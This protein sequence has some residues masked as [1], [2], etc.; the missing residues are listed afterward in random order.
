MSIALIDSR[1]LV[2]LFRDLLVVLCLLMFCETSA[3]EWV[4]IERVYDGDT[5]VLDDGTKVRV[6]GIDTP[7]THHPEIGEE[8]GGKSATRLARYYLEGKRVWLIG[9]ARDVYGRRLARVR[10]KDNR[11]YSDIVRA[12]GYDKNVRSKSSRPSASRSI[13]DAKYRRIW[14]KGYFRK[15]GRWVS[16][17]YRRI[18]VKP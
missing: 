1:R 6:Q 13:E 7:E 9:N 12:H 11:Y 16:G 4:R 8:P 17:H 5:F 18:R 10:L 2:M 14:V 15:N 3:A